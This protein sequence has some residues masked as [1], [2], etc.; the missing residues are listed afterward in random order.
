MVFEVVAPTVISMT[1]CS[2]TTV[3]IAGRK[4]RWSDVSVW[5]RDHRGGLKR[6]RHW[7]EVRDLELAA[8]EDGTVWNHRVVTLEPG[9]TRDQAEARWHDSRVASFLDDRAARGKRPAM[10]NG[11]DAEFL[12][13]VD[14]I[15]DLHGCVTTLRDLADQLGYDERWIHPEGRRIVLLGDFADKNLVAGN[16][17][18]TVRQ[19]CALLVTGRAVAVMGNHDRKLLRAVKAVMEAERAFSKRVREPVFRELPKLS[20]HVIAAL[21]AANS[22]TDTLKTALRAAA[23]WMRQSSPK[24]GIDLTLGE[25]ADADDALDMCKLINGVYGSLSHQMSIDGGTMIAVHAATRSDLI[26]ANSRK[27]R[28]YSMFG[29]VT[30]KLD[31]NGYPIRRDWTKNWNDERVVVYGHEIQEEGPRF[32]GAANTAIGIDTGAYESGDADGFRGLTAL[33]WPE[34]EIVSVSTAALDILEGDKKARALRRAEAAATTTRALTLIEAPGLQRAG[35]RVLADELAE[36]GAAGWVCGLDAVAAQQGGQIREVVVCADGDELSG[37]M[38]RFGATR[39][40]EKFVAGIGSDFVTV[41]ALGRGTAIES[42]INASD[43]DLPGLMVSLWG[44]GSWEVPEE[45]GMRQLARTTVRENPTAALEAVAASAALRVPLNRDVRFYLKSHHV[46]LERDDVAGILEWVNNLGAS[47]LGRF[48]AACG[49]T[50]LLPAVFPAQVDIADVK[51]LTMQS[52][53]Q[54]R[55]ETLQKWC[56]VS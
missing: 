34:R 12:S 49:A 17:L 30:G 44:D 6:I 11:I 39:L 35:L 20:E 43:V 28:D 51:A 32:S 14:V 26:G 23:G 29:D 38:E 22:D 7:K 47:E 16:N 33:R 36:L 54:T 25:L 13:H 5:T 41:V 42:H 27:A 52:D 4:V 18:A 1:R 10:P 3:R 19:V 48:I 2:D 55:L 53:P 37:I 9:T 21:R 45:I 31:E 24:Y 40:G 56:S 50:G 8:L 15:G 46:E